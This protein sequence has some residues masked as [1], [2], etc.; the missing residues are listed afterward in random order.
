MTEH[1]QNGAIKDNMKNIHRNIL[2]KQEIIKNVSCI[3]KFDNVL[4]S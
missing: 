2:T 1:Q 4:F 3:K